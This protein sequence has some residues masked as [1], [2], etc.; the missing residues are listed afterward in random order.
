MLQRLTIEIVSAC[1]E[2]DLFDEQI[3]IALVISLIEVERLSCLCLSQCSHT[4]V[5]IKFNNLHISVLKKQPHGKELLHNIAETR[6]E[7]VHKRPP[8]QT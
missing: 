2:M 8:T 1:L 4:L 5:I 3:S 7:I 6:A